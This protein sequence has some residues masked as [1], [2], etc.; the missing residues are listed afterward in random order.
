MRGLLPAKFEDAEDA[1]RKLYPMY[2]PSNG[3]RE[4]ARAQWDSE[5]TTPER[6]SAQ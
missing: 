6:E 2:S 4:F 5:L 3:M 1:Y